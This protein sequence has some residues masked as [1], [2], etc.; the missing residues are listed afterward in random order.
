MMMNLSVLTVHTCLVF[1]FSALRVTLMVYFNVCSILCYCVC[2]LLVRK[3]RVPEYILVSI[4]EILF[5]S[6]LAVLC[7]GSGLGFQL[8]FIDSIAIVL[9]AQYFSVHI[10]VKPVN[11]PG[12]SA[13]CG[14]MYILSLI[15]DR[16][17]EPLYRLSED[18]A[19]GCTM[20]NSVLTL[21][22]IILFFSLLTNLAANFELEL[23]RQASHDSLTGLVNRH[24]L[25]KYMNTIHQTEDMKNYWLAILDIDDFKTVNDRYGHLCG[26]FVLR[27]VAE[28]IQACCGERM[29]C[30]WGG[31]EFMVVGVDDA[32]QGGM[33]ALLEEIR[34]TIASKE[35][36]YGDEIKLHLTVTLGAARYHK[37]QSL[38]TWVNRADVR[39]YNGKQA[40]KNRVIMADV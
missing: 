10:G 9:F 24:Y 2:F 12:L 26:D 25:T 38:D 18:V 13:V 28:A 6:F 34:S 4:A 5:H 27:S 11:G 8:Y 21:G 20:L 32:R 30:R 14:V 39:L 19:F 17:H 7:V 31:E 22:F 37:G 3:E 35:F 33:N 36:V 15:F 1:L 16:I 23:T 29:V 40:G